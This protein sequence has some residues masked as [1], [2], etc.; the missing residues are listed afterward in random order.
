MSP[1]AE[2]E[3][4]YLEYYEDFLAKV[5]VLSR[6]VRESGWLPEF[7]IGVG[8]GGLV[9]AVYI[10]HQLELPM[11]SIDH[12]SKVPGF[13]DELLAKV[14]AMTTQGTRVLFVDDINDSG[15]TIDYIRGLLAGNGY[16]AENLRFAVVINNQSSKV[17][18]DL[19]ADMIDRAED[20]RW[21]VFPWEAVGTRESI[22]DEALSVP[23]RLS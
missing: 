23:E 1:T 7:V 5:R 10:S 13:A 17:E 9:P 18:V 16:A 6:K 19:W 14:A 21:F 11:L 22:V 15:G 4:H 20:K 2:P 8:R 12:S 3:L